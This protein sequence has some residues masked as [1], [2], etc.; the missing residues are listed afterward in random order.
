MATMFD[1]HRAPSLASD[2]QRGPSSASCDSQEEGL[3]I[4][5][6]E[7]SLARPANSSLFVRNVS[8]R[9]T[10]DDLREMFRL[11]AFAF[12]QQFFHAYQLSVTFDP[13]LSSKFDFILAIHRS[14]IY[15]GCPFSFGSCRAFGPLFDVYIPRDFYS[16]R[17]RGFAYV[18]YEEPEDA[19]AAQ[20]K[21]HHALLYDR[22]LEVRM[23]Y[24]TSYR[25]VL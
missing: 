15:L 16:K 22:R 9:A 10:S 8:D 5:K 21:L 13:A 6:K 19:A 25:T 7:L 3:P 11:D 20:E 1:H 4:G 17:P 12:P 23:V 24:Y 18:Q 2:R 14:F